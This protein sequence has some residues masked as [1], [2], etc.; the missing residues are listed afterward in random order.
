MAVVCYKG[1]IVRVPKGPQETEERAQDRAWWIAKALCE[2]PAG[3]D[4]KPFGQL[5]CESHMW[6][7]RKYFAMDY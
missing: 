3:G 4:A 7:N 1:R 2:P 5:L 6:C